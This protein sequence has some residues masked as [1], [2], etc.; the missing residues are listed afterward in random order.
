MRGREGERE[1]ILILGF[2]VQSP[3]TRLPCL[4]GH[5]RHWTNTGPLSKTRSSPCTT[6]SRGPPRQ[7][8]EP[9]A[10]LGKVGRAE[11]SRPSFF[12]KPP[13]RLQSLEGE[14]RLSRKAGVSSRKRQ[15][16]RKKVPPTP[17][18]KH[19]RLHRRKYR[20][21]CL[22]ER[23][24]WLSLGSGTVSSSCLMC[25][26]SIFG[27]DKG[28]EP[29]VQLPAADG[30]GMGTRCLLCPHH[31]LGWTAHL[32]CLSMLAGHSEDVPPAREQPGALRWPRRERGRK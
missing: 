8:G 12:S 30:E 10:D 18:L 4:L 25:F 21:R 16:R 9:S 20:G 11:L 15:G 17:T 26:S 19:I 13:T 23:E 14:V 5:R 27:L 28:S 1:K 31:V 3:T 29:D 32:P 6:H 2:P 22:S 7:H 24:A